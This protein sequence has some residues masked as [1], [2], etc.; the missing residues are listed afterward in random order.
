MHQV[1]PI[2]A[3]EAGQVSSQAVDWQVGVEGKQAFKA[4]ERVVQIATVA[5]S[6]EP[7]IGLDTASQ[8]LQ[9]LQEILPL[10]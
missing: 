7:A 4:K 9:N 3:A 10:S 8:E 2:A 5:A 1:K 6:P